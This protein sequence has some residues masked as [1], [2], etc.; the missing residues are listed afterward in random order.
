LIQ[1]FGLEMPAS[2]ILVNSPGTHGVVG[3]STALTPS[4][5]L[6]CGSFGGNSTTDN[7]TYSHLM[8][9]KRIAYFLP[10]RLAQFTLS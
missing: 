6:G 7:V 4:L 8:N 9:V 3:I 1:R 10:E 2:R 5:T